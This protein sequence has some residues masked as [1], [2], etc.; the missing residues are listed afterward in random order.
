MEGGRSRGILIFF[1][2]FLDCFTSYNE[3]VLHIYNLKFT[4]KKK[5]KLSA[6]LTPRKRKITVI[7][8]QI[9]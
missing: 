8:F 5:D 3:C 2:I 1:N 7:D 4:I 9:I 6:H